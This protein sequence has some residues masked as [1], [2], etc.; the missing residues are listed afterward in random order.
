[1]KVS[2]LHKP[3]NKSRKNKT[4]RLNRRMKN[5]TRKYKNKRTNRRIKN[6]A[7]NFESKRTNLRKFKKRTN[8]HNFKKRNNRAKPLLL[9]GLD[10]DCPEFVKDIT[11]TSTTYTFE[12]EG[13]NLGLQSRKNIRG[14]N[15]PTEGFFKHVPG[16]PVFFLPY[17][18]DVIEV[19]KKGLVNVNGTKL[20]DVNGKKRNIIDYY[21]RDCLDKNINLENMDNNNHNVTEIMNNTDN[22]IFMKFNKFAVYKGYDRGKRKEK[23]QAKQQWCFLMGLSIILLNK[24]KVIKDGITREIVF[25]KGVAL[26]DLRR[27]QN[28]YLAEGDA[29]Q[30]EFE[31]LVKKDPKHEHEF[32]IKNEEIDEKYEGLY[33]SG[34]LK[35]Q[36]ILSKLREKE[37]KVQSLIDTFKRV[38]DHIKLPDVQQ[39][40][41]SYSSL[42]PLGKYTNN[43][44]EYL[45]PYRDDSVYKNLQPKLNLTD[46]I[47]A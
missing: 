44:T 46:T 3:C 12:N 42:V 47:S 30:N 15:I 43:G 37:T 28:K 20:V 21:L 1:M 29:N 8:R 45:F 22:W 39:K 33:Q 36:D 24:F 27:L 2:S 26:E 35:R 41:Q 13:S 38:V 34:K 23:Q 40:I 19:D 10:R 25:I 9:G 18:N 14:V 17:E 4:K 7:R 6:R 31:I 32:E 16:G 11:T 5:R